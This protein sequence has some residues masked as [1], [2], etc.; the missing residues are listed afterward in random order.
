MGR[1]GPVRPSL[2]TMGKL[3]NTPT[4][5]DGKDGACQDAN[6]P[7]NGLLGRQAV[8]YGLP[9]QATPTDGKPTSKN[10]PIEAPPYLNPRFVSALMGIPVGW[11]ELDSS[12]ML[13]SEHSV[14]RKFRLWLHTHSSLLHVALSEDDAA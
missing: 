1:V 3:W 5:R 6:V 13:N 9:V 7:T 11:T 2:E 14:M 12:G 10:T 4:S 8:R